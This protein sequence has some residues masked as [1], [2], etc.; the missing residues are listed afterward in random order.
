MRKSIVV[1]IG[2][3]CVVVLSGCLSMGWIGQKECWYRCQLLNP[4]PVPMDCMSVC[5][6]PKDGE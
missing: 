2:M 1:M 5:L 3:V 6:I 4:T